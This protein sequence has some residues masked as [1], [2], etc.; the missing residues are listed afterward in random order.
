MALSYGDPGQVVDEGLFAARGFGDDVEAAH[1]SFHTARVV[2][3]G[4]SADA[5]LKR[6]LEDRAGYP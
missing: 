2:T 3:T 5:L 1:F 4:S 6:F